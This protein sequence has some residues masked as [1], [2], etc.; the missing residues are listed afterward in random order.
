M[1]LERDVALLSGKPRPEFGHR[2]VINFNLNYHT[3][4]MMS[5]PD[6]Q[7]LSELTVTT[8]PFIDF[9]DFGVG[10]P[11]VR[12]IWHHVNKSLLRSLI[13]MSSR[14]IARLG[15]S[16]TLLVVMWVLRIC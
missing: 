11:E 4:I 13:T 8:I 10:N 3:T 15:S 5:D 9:A 7:T 16:F 14:L 6:S 12:A 1:G 2:I